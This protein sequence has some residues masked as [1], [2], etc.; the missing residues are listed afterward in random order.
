MKLVQRVQDILL[1]PKDTWVVIEA[2]PAD[3][4][5][6]F[7]NY[8]LI[9]AAIPAVAGF[10]G[11]SLVGVGAFGFSYKVPF[12]TGL[13]HAILQYGLSLAGIYVLSLIVDALAPT[14]KGVKNPGNALKLVAYGATASF[15]GGIFSILPVMSVLGILAGLYSIYLIYTGIPVL[16][17]SPPEQS[18]GYTALI[19]VIGIVA[20]VVF[21]AVSAALTAGSGYAFGAGDVSVKTA[22]GDITLNTDKLKEFADRAEQASQRIEKAQQSGD[23]AAAG[24]AAAEMVGALTGQNGAPLSAADLKAVLPESIADLKR[25]SFEAN[26]SEVMGFAVS[27]AKAEYKAE[28]KSVR[29][30]I[31]D[32]GGFGG[33]MAVAAWANV[34]V[35]KETS[36]AIEKVYKQ[37]KR[38]VRE[39]YRKDGSSAEY[40]VVLE[41]GVVVEAHGNQVG[42]AEIKRAV[43]GLD[44]GKIEAMKRAAKTT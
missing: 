5:G 6:L 10:V 28:T 7:K 31:T 9:L 19:I 23:P 26:S 33:L 17:K 35:D 37:G 8:L 15:L 22:Q 39:T 24:K 41:N 44:L 36:D 11:T 4:A 43:E 18:I 13:V 34:T 27:S 12:F 30:S 42:F 38:S 20:G 32:A 2:E 40:T 1:K 29:L 25:D 21:G 3:T 14:F 16:M